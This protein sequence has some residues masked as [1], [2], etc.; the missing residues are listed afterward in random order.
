[1]RLPADIMTGW[2]SYPQP[3]LLDALRHSIARSLSVSPARLVVGAG[4]DDLI[5]LL[6]LWFR[7]SKPRGY[8]P[9][10]TCGSLSFAQYRLA[11]ERHGLRIVFGPCPGCDG[12]E[13]TRITPPL[14]RSGTYLNWRTHAY[15]AIAE[16]H[17]CGWE[18]SSLH[19]R[20][21]T[22]HDL[23]LSAFGDLRRLL[24]SGEPG[25]V[26]LFSFSKFFRLP[27]ARLGFLVTP[28]ASMAQELRSL[29]VPYPI[30]APALARGL[31]VLRPKSL[32]VAQRRFER[33]AVLAG[34][35]ERLLAQ[36]APLGIRGFANP[37]H[38]VLLHLTPTQAA[39]LAALSGRHTIPCWTGRALCHELA[40]PPAGSIRVALTA[41]SLRLIEVAFQVEHQG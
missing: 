4:V 13:S 25:S 35:G 3:P 8:T 38:I 6:T 18:P 39:A 7:R 12:I 2:N 20:I 26:V 41:K 17:A 19:P 28:R 24:Q 27:G 30:A 33:Q 29:Q 11:A 21:L 16:T 37:Y 32:N 23:S 22:A 34:R 5:S 1:M 31:A 40:A 15:H 9:T 36:L 14:P 10:V